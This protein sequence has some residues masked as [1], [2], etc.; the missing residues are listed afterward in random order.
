MTI[1]TRKIRFSRL[2]I[3]KIALFAGAYCSVQPPLAANDRET[4]RVLILYSYDKQQDIFY[5]EQTFRSSLGVRLSDRVEYYTEYLDLVRFPESRHAAL[6][7]KL[8]TLKLSEWKPDLVITVSYPALKFLLTDGKGLFPGTPIVVTCVGEE[9]GN[10]LKA[11]LASA[12]RKHVTGVLLHNQQLDTVK[13]A[14]KLQPNTQRVV[15][16]TGTTTLEKFW[17]NEFQKGISGFNREVTFTYLTDLPMD[18]ILKQVANLPPHTVIF[19]TYFFLD[20]S[21]RFFYPEEAL[22]R[23]TSSSH[24]PVYSIF[25]S[26]LGHGL[27]GGQM[28]DYEDVGTRTAEAASRALRG[29]RPSTNPFV[30]ASTSH[31]IVDWRQLK[32]W[33]I[34][35]SNLPPGSV[36]LFQQPTVWETYNRFIVGGIFLVLAE[37]LLILGLLWQRARRRKV[38]ASVVERLT[39]ESLLSDLSTAFINL[40]QEQV[41]ANIE[42]GLGRIAEYLNIER[43]TLR[44]F[45]AKRTELT[46]TFSWTGKGINPA[47]TVVETNQFPRWTN[48]LLRGEVVLSSGV[49]GLPEEASAERE[50]LRKRGAMSVALVPLRAGGEILGVMSFVSTERQVLWTEDLVKQLKIFAEIFSNALT[51]KRAEEALRESEERLRLAVQAGRIYAFEWDTTTD[52]IVRSGECADIFNWANDPTQDTG[53]QF[54]TKV[55]PDDREAYTTTEIGLTPENPT[56]RTSYR[57]LR[58]DGSVIWLEESGHGFFDGRGRML[59]TIGMVADITERKLAQEK[60]RE[61]EER[62]RLVANSAPALIWMAGTDKLCTFFNKGWLDFTGRTMEQELGNGWATGVHPDD[63]ERCLRTYSAAFDARADFKLEYRLRRFDGEYR[64]IVDYGVPRFESN[65]FCGYIGSCVD[66]TDRKLSEAWLQELSGRLIHA[67]E[68]ER[69]RIAR[70]LH[71]DV[72]QRMALL[73]IGLKK[74]EQETAGL[75]SKARQQLQN[76]ADVATEAASSI[77]DLS[78]Q[79]HPSKLDTLGLVASLGGYCRE[80]SER[81][82]LQ[83]Q[84]VHHEVPG[85]IPKD[86]TLCL[87][88]IAQEALRNVVKHSGAAEAKVE[89]SSH[90]DRIDLCISDSG[91]G[92]DPGYEQG[93][94]LGLISMR[95]RLRLVEGHLSIESQPSRGTQIRVRVPLAISSARVPTEGKAQKAGA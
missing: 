69:M 31:S 67:Q 11:A 12:G 41:H 62:F 9:F 17:L 82:D 54:V 43:I 24:A 66:I 95:E 57:V 53:R 42:K 6:L 70:E 75:S 94:G 46:A 49:Y 29:E 55:H 68:E 3:I 59:R 80:F 15:V 16:V 34:N 32:R 8:L 40:S 86:V 88:R 35:E 33:N 38:E 26:Y 4:K 63:V 10:E 30:V 51:R 50:Y 58:P 83:V 92:F 91:A 56:Y 60:L 27:V 61:S 22:D 76:I 72:S 84:F 81:H 77:H 28:L 89:L 93:R 45:S 36:V 2:T 39:F 7:V 87:F 13:L 64:W 5:G 1:A 85:Q 21:G 73:Q 71:D 47:P 65:T 14:L 23:I 74:F 37:A 25:R 78:H 79:L 52:V 20:A 19:Y 44:E 90:G 18:E 48:L